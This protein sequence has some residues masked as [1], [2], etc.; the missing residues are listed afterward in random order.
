MA[1]GDRRA[2]RTAI[3]TAAARAMHRDEPP[4]WVID[5]HLAAGL[6]G[7]EG[8]EISAQLQRALS[9]ED[10]LTFTRWICVRSRY[11]EDLV[12]RSVVADLVRQYLILGAGLDTF[13]YR[14][15][16]L[17][18]RLRVFE[19]DYPASRAWKRERL[20]ANDVPVPPNVTFAPIDFE[21]QTLRQGL[22][23]AG[24][25]FDQPTIV[26]WVGVTM[27]LT[28]EA[29]EATLAT[30]TQ[31]PASSRLVLTY[32]LPL[33]ALCGAAKRT[34][35]VLYNTAAD[36]GEPFVSLFRPGEIE[37]LLR[38]YGYTQ[39]EH[40]GPKEA[41]AAYFPGR[42]DVR[43]GGAQRLVTATIERSA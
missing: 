34:H 12:E 41:L 33:S 25:D 38:R 14:R 22:E 30:V 6:A 5:D 15:P 29:I 24:V 11:P 26:C 20:H 36:M 2:S 9:A 42:Q 1:T 16:D 21:R 43:F 10:L 27:Y 7:D 40:F 28:P 4:P 39:I 19:V 18:E 8:A 3:M 23:R 31:F 13:A 17:V 37:R 35:T 32:N